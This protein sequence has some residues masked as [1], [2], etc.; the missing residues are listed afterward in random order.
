MPFR[1][2]IEADLAA[3][4][5]GFDGEAGACDLGPPDARTIAVHHDLEVDRRL[6]GVEAADRVTAANDGAIVA[7]QR[8]GQVLPREILERL[9]R[10]AGKLDA[11]HVPCDILHGGDHEGQCLRLGHQSLLYPK[12]PWASLRPHVS[13]NPTDPC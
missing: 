2:W 4:A 6:S 8:Q 3:R 7:D 5:D 1:V 9:E 12:M 10:W 13:M 11:T